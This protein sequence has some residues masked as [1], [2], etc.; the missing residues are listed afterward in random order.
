MQQHRTRIIVLCTLFVGLTVWSYW[1]TLAVMADL[2]T[3]KP[4]YSHGWLVPLLAF[5]LLWE[6]IKSLQ[7]DR[8]MPPEESFSPSWWGLPVLAVSLGLRVFAAHYYMEWFDFL[9]IIP[10]VA[11]L[12]LLIGGWGAIRVAWAPIAYLFFMIPL[13]YTAEVMLRGPLREV[14]TIA[15]TYAMQTLGLPAF[16][17]GTVVVVNDVR[18]GVVEACSGLRMLMIFFALSTAVALLCRRPLWHRAIIVLS[19][20]PIALIANITR[21][22]TTG[23]LY[24]LGYD[25]LA[26]VVFHDL[27]GWLMMPFA[28]VLLGAEVWFL[29]NLFIVE[30]KIPLSVGLHNTSDTPQAGRPDSPQ[31]AT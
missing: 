19:A 10:F 22:T 3:R 20:A 5:Y 14:G 8:R 2:W 17:E 9:S 23:L 30:K 26:E 11:G 16:A 24:A 27:A 12:T 4:E 18:I 6:G 21:I 31:P 25:Q 15:S 29:D 1:T 7:K 28:L 13:P